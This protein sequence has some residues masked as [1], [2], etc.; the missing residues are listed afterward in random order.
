MIDNQGYS[1]QRNH[2]S[3]NIRKISKVSSINH[4]KTWENKMQISKQKNVNYK[5]KWTQWNLLSKNRKYNLV[6][7]SEQSKEK[8]KNYNTKLLIIKKLMLSIRLKFKGTGKIGKNCRQLSEN[9]K[10]NSRKFHE[11]LR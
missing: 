7:R 6:I 11:L 5:R 4:S 8:L 9:W 10:K 3:N 2:F 1:K